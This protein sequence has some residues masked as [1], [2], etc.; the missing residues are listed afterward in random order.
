MT[1]PRL[2]VRA[3]GLRAR[4]ELLTTAA[5]IVLCASIVVAAFVLPSSVD[6]FLG[7]AS[8]ADAE[9]PKPLFLVIAAAGATGAALAAALV[10]WAFGNV[11]ANFAETPARGEIKARLLTH[12]AASGALLSGAAGVWVAI[13]LGNESS[14]LRSTLELVVAAGGVVGTIAAVLLVAFAPGD[15]RALR[16]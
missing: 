3:S 16:D 15:K 2:Q 13:L 9:Q 6:I 5:A 1:M 4:P 8:S 10:A 12:V 14:E 11:V 7:P